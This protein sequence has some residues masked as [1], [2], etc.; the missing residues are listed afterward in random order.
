MSTRERT[1]ESVARNADA[2]LS[3]LQNDDM[4][5][6]PSLLMSDDINPSADLEDIPM[7]VDVEDQPPSNTGQAVPANNEFRLPNWLRGMRPLRWAPG[8]NPT[9]T[10]R[11]GRACCFF[12]P[13]GLCNN[14]NMIVNGFCTFHLNLIFNIYYTVGKN[15]E[16][17]EKSGQPSIY[18]R[19]LS[20]VAQP[21]P[22]NNAYTPVFPIIEMFDNEPSVEDFKFYHMNKLLTSIHRGNETYSRH[23]NF[24]HSMVTLK[25]PNQPVSDGMD[26]MTLQFHWNQWNEYNSM[27]L[28]TNPSNAYIYYSDDGSTMRG[29]NLS[30]FT[31]ITQMVC[32][33]FAVPYT[34]FNKQPFYSIPCNYMFNVAR[35][36]SYVNNLCS[37]GTT[38]FEGKI[39]TGNIATLSMAYRDGSSATNK[40]MI[41]CDVMSPASKFCV[42]AKLRPSD[43]VLNKVNIIPGPAN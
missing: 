37:S 20:Y 32:R 10:S 19:R 31:T 1:I 42:D 14:H 3:D 15:Y 18:K 28:L 8:S 22:L 12:A 33:L 25:S 35:H 9:K 4:L 17:N 38:P 43:S 6:T 30:D 5:T 11:C 26:R 41:Y 7:D 13:L 39:I 23:A 21:Q 34:A 2:V 27:Y 40:S 24:F 36:L 29:Y 16:Y